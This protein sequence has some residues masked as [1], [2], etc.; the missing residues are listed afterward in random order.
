LALIPIAYGGDCAWLRGLSWFQGALTVKDPG[1]I[2]PATPA[3]EVARL[4]GGTEPILVQAGDS[5]HRLAELAVQNPACRTLC[6]I[7]DDERLIGLISVTEL[8]NDIFLKVVPEEFLGEIQDVP[9][10]L[11]YAEQIGARTAG[12]IMRPSLSVAADDTIRQV[13]RHLH[14]SALDG[15]PVTD[16]DG[17]VIA[18]LDQLELLMAWIAAT[19]RGLLLQPPTS[20]PTE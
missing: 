1:P 17:R 15:L 18:Y 7:D 8:L 12:D 11:R 3:L 2:T 4:V 16:A 5:L 10:A 14:Q 13:F 6:V 19:G 20:G 9:G